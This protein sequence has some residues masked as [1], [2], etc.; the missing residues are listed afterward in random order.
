MQAVFFLNQN[1]TPEARKEIEK[2]LASSEIVEKFH[3]VSREEAVLR[4]K[5]KFP[6]L[7]QVV[8]SLGFNPFPP[9]IEVTF[10]KKSRASSQVEDLI[11]SIQNTPGVEEVQY[12]LE[13]VARVQAFGRVITAIGFFL[14][15]ILIL[16]SFFIISNVIKLNLLSRKDEIDI[17]RLVGASNFFIRVPF[18]LEGMT[19]GLIGGLASLILL[20]LTIQILPL[21]LGTSLGALTELIRFR[22]LSTSQS[23]LLVSSGILIGFLGSLSSVSRLLREE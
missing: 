10:S 1:I 15:G 7:S 3:F 8:D 4:F 11:T 9:S 12:N 20:F 6:E 18:V 19:L 13:W 2:K 17:L 16:A 5:A 23:L 14:G 21:Y 22:Y